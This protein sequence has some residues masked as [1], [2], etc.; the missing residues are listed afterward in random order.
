M[1]LWM[2]HFL[3]TPLR[4]SLPRHVLLTLTLVG[5]SAAI[6]LSTDNLELLLGIEVRITVHIAEEL[7]HREEL[8]SA[9]LM[10]IPSP[11]FNYPF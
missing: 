3:Y 6:G 5:L 2:E 9:W 7:Q 8:M 10:Y 11:P 1:R 4:K